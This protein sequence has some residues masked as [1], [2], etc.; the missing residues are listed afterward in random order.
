MYDNS[1]EEYMRT[2]LGYT[3]SNM[4]DIYRNDCYY[5]EPASINFQNSEL[6]NMYPDIYRKVYPLV[7]SRCADLA[8]V[9]ISAKQLD[10][11]TDT[12]IASINIDLK[13]ETKSSKTQED[14]AP[15]QN[16]FLRDLIKILIIREILSRPR[17]PNF[18]PGPFVPQRPI[19]PRMF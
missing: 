18:H 15:R 16:D 8:D 13:I 10:E 6:E 7:C 17:R 3:P 14:R 1:Y 4:S 9:N 5:N 2:V 19:M 11:L 12:I